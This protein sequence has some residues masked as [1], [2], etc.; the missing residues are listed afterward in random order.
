L[1][2]A[3]TCALTRGR[4]DEEGARTRSLERE[5]GCYRAISNKASPSVTN[6]IPRRSLPEPV[7]FPTLFPGFQVYSAVTNI[8]PGI[9]KMYSDNKVGNWAFP[10]PIAFQK[11]KSRALFVRKQ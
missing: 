4:R 3:N 7:Q 9:Q 2:R 5:E 1:L 8:I 11:G 10:Q 6:I